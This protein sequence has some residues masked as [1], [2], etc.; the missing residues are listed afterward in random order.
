MYLDGVELDTYA[1]EDIEYRQINPPSGMSVPGI[2]T[3]APLNFGRSIAGGGTSPGGYIN[4]S[5]DEVA[6]WN[7]ALTPTE[8]QNYYDSFNTTLQDAFWSNLRGNRISSSDA[9]DSVLMQVNGIGLQNKLINY[10]IKKVGVIDWNPFNWF[11]HTIL[12]TESLGI[13]DWQTE[14]GTFFFNVKVE[15]LANQSNELVVGSANDS[16]PV[17]IIASPPNHYN[18]SVN[19]TISFTH[20]SYDEDDMLRVKW[21]FGDGTSFVV[22]NYSLALTPGL[23]NTLHNYSSAGTYTVKLNVSEMARNQSSVDSVNVKVIGSGINI[24]PVINSP[25]ETQIY[26]NWVNFNISSSYVINCSQTMSPYD[27]IIG[28]LQCKYIH[29]PGNRTISGGHDLLVNWTITSTD[30]RDRISRAGS[31]N[32]NYSSVVDFKLLFDKK[33]ERRAVVE[34]NYI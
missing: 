8:I 28:N 32:N 14:L 33:K 24:I 12:H 1:Y 27:L 25:T 10:T 5:I 23:G 30:G 13:S 31:W 18:A 21:D 6:I 4:G 7:R 17:A 15:N 22:E 9:G 29:A 26:E 34:L 3:N 20:A 2:N 11:T 16:T 19:Q